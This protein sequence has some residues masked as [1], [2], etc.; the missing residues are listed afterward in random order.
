LLA[1]ATIE[2]AGVLC[3]ED[4]VGSLE[5]GKAADLVLLDGNAPHLL[6]QH[7]L[8]SDVVRFATRGEVK[9]TIVAGRVLYQD[10]V[11]ATID[12]ER[13]RADAGAG[14]THVRKVV[15]SRRYKPFPAF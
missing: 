15:E 5:I 13:L 11:F 1:M 10:G 14:A 4:M 2:S 12:I 6:A 3:A 9:A 8:A 7:S